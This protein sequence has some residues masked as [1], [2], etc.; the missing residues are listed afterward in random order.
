[1]LKTPPLGFE[2]LRPLAS[3]VQNSPYKFWTFA[4]ATIEAQNSPT[5]FCASMADSSGCARV[6]S[7]YAHDDPREFF[8]AASLADS[9]LM[10]V[11]I[12]TLSGQKLVGDLDFGCS[13]LILD[14]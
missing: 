7:K 6:M 5:E 3:D 2:H 13:M 8:V 12:S 14:E 11:Y 1:M 4:A 10:V 9:D